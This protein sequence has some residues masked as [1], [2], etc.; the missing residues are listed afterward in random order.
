MTPVERR[1]ESLVDL[2]LGRSTSTNAS[3]GS[4]YDDRGSDP[5]TDL[6]GANRGSSSRASVDSPGSEAQGSSPG[7]FR[8]MYRGQTRFDFVGRRRVWFIVSAVIIVAGLVS[9]GTRGLNLGIDFRGGTSWTVLA[10]QVTQAKATSLVEA[11][12][13]NQPVVQL[14]GSGSNRHVQVQAD[15]NNLPPAQQTAI[16]AKVLVVMRHMGTELGVTDVGPTWG[17]Q[18]T[19]RALIALFA[20]FF[21]VVIYISFRFEPKMALAAFIAMIHDLLVAVGVYSLAGFQVTPDTVIA[22]LTILGYSLYDTV[23]VFDRVREN[24]KGFGAS[25]RMTYSDMVNL[26][27]NQTLARSINTSLVAIMPVL[28]VLVVGAEILGATTLQDY[29]LA[30]FVGLLSGAYSSIFIASPVLA[31]LKEREPRYLSIRHKLETRGDRLGILTPSAAAQLSVAGSGSLQR[32]GA[33]RASPKRPTTSGGAIRPGSAGTAR[34]RSGAAGSRNSKNVSKTSKAPT[35]SAMSASSGVPAG[36]MD[37]PESQRAVGS[38][39]TAHGRPRGPNGPSGSG[40]SQRKAPPRPRKGAK[41]KSQKGKK[42]R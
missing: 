9:M 8:R 38:A 28:A 12:G 18:V 36:S 24:S 42:R 23:V 3:E 16:K 14:I 27:M 20:F 1:D 41:G 29:G 21:A 37:T 19:Q 32:A 33:G 2:E 39:A 31:M 13:L 11:A 4:E 34:S 40:A 10:P 30:L 35:S 7:S 25:G 6:D 26:S 17:G 15:L 22:I 5:D